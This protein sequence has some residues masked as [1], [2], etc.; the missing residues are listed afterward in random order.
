MSEEE[1][2]AAMIAAIRRSVTATGCGSLSAVEEALV[3]VLATLALTHVELHR[4]VCE[5]EK[6]LKH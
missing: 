1:Q 6:Q 3:G 4:R 2:R 5:L